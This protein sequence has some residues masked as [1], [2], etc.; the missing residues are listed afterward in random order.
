MGKGKVEFIPIRVT[1]KKNSFDL[2]KAILDSIDENGQSIKDGDILVISSKFVALSEGRVVK[3][4]R[5]KPRSEAK[6]LA[7]KFHLP[8][9]LAE[10]VLREADEILG[11]APG[12][13]LTAK[14]GALLANAGIDRSNVPKGYGMLHPKDPFHKAEQLRKKL[15]IRTGKKLGIV[16]SDSRLMPTRR[17]TTGIALAVSGF[18]PV[19]DE[20]GKRDLFGNVMK[21]TQRAIADDIS[22]GAHLI[23]GEADE[24]IPIV[25]VR[26]TR[27]K[28][29]DEPIDRRRMGISHEECLYIRGLMKPA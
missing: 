16:I 7:K 20:R 4:S 21:V 28:M 14:E 8:S 3:L 15:L 6:M 10:L 11:G 13:I 1:P 12:F 24:A 23:M 26:N 18:E 22:A 9:P 2:V 5:V 17:G 27:I 29:V 19:K 25:I